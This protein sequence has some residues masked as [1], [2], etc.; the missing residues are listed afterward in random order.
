MAWKKNSPE[1]MALLDEAASTIPCRRKMM[2]GGVAYFAND[3]MFAGLH[4]NMVFL[5]LS[6]DDREEVLSTMDEATLFEPMEGRPMKEY[7][8]LPE[9]VFNDAPALHGWLE[10]G[11]GFASSLPPKGTKPRKGRVAS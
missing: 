6:P 9:S 10:R 8:V 2:F 5:R 3:N 7:V 4:Q 11:F 1:M